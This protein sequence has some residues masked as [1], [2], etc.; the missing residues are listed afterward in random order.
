MQNFEAI[1]DECAECLR[2]ADINPDRSRFGHL[3]GGVVR[4][5]A[6]DA[7]DRQQNGESGRAL[8]EV[9]FF[10]GSRFNG[11]QGFATIGTNDEDIE[12]TALEK[13]GCDWAG[14]TGQYSNTEPED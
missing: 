6:R 13:G 1:A 9:S 8:V 7:T 11:A 12:A 5:G 3:V 4:E 2:S 10:C 14:F